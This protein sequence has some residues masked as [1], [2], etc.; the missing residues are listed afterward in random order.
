MEKYYP[1][2]VSIDKSKLATTFLTLPILLEIQLPGEHR[3]KRLNIT[4][5]VVFG[6]KLGSHTKVVYKVNGNEG[7]D[8]INNDFNINTLR[9]GYTA[10]VGYGALSVFA[11]YYATPMFEKNKGPELYPIA[12]G[13]ALNF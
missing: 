4:T 11:N 12:V 5:G 1:K 7:T 13:L 8:K 10:R 6:L 9:Y 2:N 3:N